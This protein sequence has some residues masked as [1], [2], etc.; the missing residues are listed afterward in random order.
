MFTLLHAD[1]PYHYIVV[2]LHLSAF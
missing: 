1:V 2:T